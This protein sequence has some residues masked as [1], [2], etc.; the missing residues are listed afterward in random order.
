MNKKI[1]IPYKLLRIGDTVAAQTKMIECKQKY[2]E[3]R[4]VILACLFSFMANYTFCQEPVSIEILS[5]QNSDS[6]KLEVLLKISITNKSTENIVYVSN[7]SK[8]DFLCGTNG[9]VFLVFQKL[10]NDCFVTEGPDCAP[11]Y[12]P[13]K[14]KDTIL[15]PLSTQNY[16]F[17][18]ASSFDRSQHAY[19]GKYRLKIGYYYRIKDQICRT[20]SDWFYVVN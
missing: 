15:P 9:A 10:V 8:T 5:E 19:R 20:Y 7:T 12:D 14:K 1:E 4:R 16:L 11:L 3:I 6:G 13:I 17:D 2:S 18:I